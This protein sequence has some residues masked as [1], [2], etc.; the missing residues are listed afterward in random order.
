VAYGLQA[1]LWIHKKEAREM[2]LPVEE[3]DKKIADIDKVIYHLR[4]E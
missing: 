4:R 2:E 1:R 3:T